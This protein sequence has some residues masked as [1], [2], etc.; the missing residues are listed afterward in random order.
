MPQ[1]IIQYDRELDEKIEEEMK[2]LDMSKADTII[3]LLKKQ[4]KLRN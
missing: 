3:E 1:T 4:V 2:K